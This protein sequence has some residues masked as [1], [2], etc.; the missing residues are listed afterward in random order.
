MKR[1]DFL[2]SSAILPVV[3]ATP[4][5][6]F[7]QTLQSNVA[8]EQGLDLIERPPLDAT[9]N[10][11]R[12]VTVLGTSNPDWRSDYVVDL[13]RRVTTLYDRH[14]R[15]E[16]FGIGATVGFGNK[17]FHDDLKQ[18]NP[19]LGIYL[20]FC[21]FDMTTQW[22]IKDREGAVY[23][24]MRSNSPLIMLEDL[25]RPDPLVPSELLPR[26]FMAGIHVAGGLTAPTVEALFAKVA[27]NLGVA[28]SDYHA[29]MWATAPHG[30]QSQ[31]QVFFDGRD[32]TDDY[33]RWLAVAV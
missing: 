10:F 11:Q 17:A 15:W 2:A 3:A 16:T 4:S 14:A 19:A 25:D 30:G 21:A 23:A 20:Q 33:V 13:Y 5:W 7:E 26:V 31:V 9:A 22:T 1:R 8:A 12:N 6:A 18:A 32:V 28:T 29:K 27:T 24:A